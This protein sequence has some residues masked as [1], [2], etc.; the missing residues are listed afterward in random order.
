MKSE[1]IVKVALKHFMGAQ[2]QGIP[3]CVR[4]FGDI[5]LETKI[6]IKRLDDVE[7]ILSNIESF[8][9]SE[10]SHRTEQHHFF[11]NS[12]IAHNVLILIKG[13]SEVW[14]KIKKDRQ[15][16]YTP[17]NSFPILAR[18]ESKIT[19]KDA[20]YLNEFQ[21]TVSQSYIG[22]FR[23]ECLDFSF[24][25]HDLSFTTTLSLADSDK[26]FLHQIEFEFDGHKE[27]TSSPDF[28]VV[29][30]IFEQMLL[31]ICLDR[32][33]GLNV[34]TKLEWLLSNKSPVSPG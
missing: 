24:Y 15:L 16:V 3:E 21:A 13:S 31:D 6:N 23:K 7:A 32:V 1:E 14:I 20:D 4:T 28:G 11:S 33:A 18:H 34:Y 17:H 5:E 22:S 2:T 27:N 26:G 19:P 8:G 29:L 9:F 12:H 25:Y 10:V 30:S